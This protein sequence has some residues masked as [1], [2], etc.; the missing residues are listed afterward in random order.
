MAY[1]LKEMQEEELQ[2]IQAI[3]M[4]DYVDHSQGN[5]PPEITLKL[6]PLQSIVRKDVHAKLDLRV[7]YTSSYPNNPPVLKLENSKGISNEQLSKLKTDLDKMAIDLCGEVMILQL[8]Q[9]IQSFLHQHN[10]PNLS[11]FEQMLANQQKQE[12]LMFQEKQI[13][14]KA[15]V[16]KDREREQDVK[17]QVKEELQ[18]RDEVLKQEKKKRQVSLS[19]SPGN[20]GSNYFEVVD[21]PQRRGSFTCLLAKEHKISV[22]IFRNSQDERKVFCSSCIG[23][24]FDGACT[25]T[26]IDESTGKLM[27][28]S[29]WKVKFPTEQK[30]VYFSNEETSDAIAKQINS[31]EQEFYFLK[32]K[33]SCRGALLYH[34]LHIERNGKNVSAKL[35]M[36]AITG[37]PL[38]SFL[39]DGGLSISLLQSFCAQLVEILSFFHSKSIV[40]RDL[41]LCN[42]FVNNNNE[43]VICGYAV[44]RRLSDFCKTHNAQGS[45][46]QVLENSFG[47]YRKLVKTGKKGDVFNLGLLLV[48]LY[49]GHTNLVYPVEVPEDAPETFKSFLNS[50]FTVNE[51]LRP[52]MQHL[53]NHSFLCEKIILQYDAKN[54]EK[55]NQNTE[56][57]FQKLEKDEVPFLFLP[58]PVVLGK[59]RLMNEFEIM[60]SLGKGGFGSVIKVR[61]KLDGNL[62]A[63]KRIP[64]NP[65]CPHLNK[66]ITREVKLLSRL[67]HENVVRYFNSWI[68]AEDIKLLETSSTDTEL[69][70]TST[71]QQQNKK[72]GITKVQTARKKRDLEESLMEV[73][74]IEE[75]AVPEFTSDNNVSWCEISST[76]KKSSSSSSDDDSYSPK[77]KINI[78]SSSLSNR[79]RSNRGESSEGII[80][81]MDDS[82]VQFGDMLDSEESEDEIRV[83]G[84]LNTATTT[85]TTTSTTT[86]EESV[87]LQYLYIQM[88]YCERSTLRNVIDEDLYKKP[89]LVGRYFREIIEGL[90]HVHSQGIIHRDLKPFNIFIDSCDR[91]KIGDFGLATS[92]GNAKLDTSVFLKENEPVQSTDDRMTGKVGTA[93]YVA[94]ELCQA[95][96]KIKFSQK[97]DMYSLGVILFEMCY[98]PLNTGMERVKL[99]GSVRSESVVFPEDFN[100]KKYKREHYVISWLL[101]HN[102]DERP[103]ATELLESGY[104]PPKIED[105]QLDELLRHTLNQTNSTRYQRLMSTLFL[106]PVTPVLDQIYDSDC[107]GKNEDVIIEA[108][109]ILQHV[110]NV[111]INIFLKHEGVFV[112]TP[113]LTPKTKIFDNMNTASFIDQNGLQLCLPCDSRVSFA[114][115]ISRNNI[116]S[117]KR[118]FFGKLF[119]NPGIISAHPLALWEC[120]FDI[121]TN[122]FSSMLPESELIFIVF[123][124]IKEFPTLYNRNFYIRLNHMSIIKAVFV[125]NNFSEETQNTIL[126]ILANTRN[127]KILEERLQTCFMELRLTEHVIN[128]LMSFLTY[129]GSL[130]KAKETL[131]LLRKSRTPVSNL[132]KEAFSELERVVKYITNF[133]IEIPVSICTSFIG[134][135]NYY[136][137][138]VFQFVAENNRKRKH[139]G[140][141]ILAVGGCYNK[142]VESMS[143]YAESS[144]LP[145]SV[146]VSIAVEKLIMSVVE[147]KRNYGCYQGS[148]SNS[149]IVCC[150]T[151]TPN[152][153]SLVPVLQDLWSANIHASLFS[154]ESQQDYTI[155]EVQE[156]CIDNGIN[157]IV[158]LKES[159]VEHVRVKSRDKE[160]FSET[161]VQRNELCDYLNHKL[162]VKLENTKEMEQSLTK[163][164]PLY[165][166]NEIS[167][168]F[169]FVSVDKVDANSKKKFTKIFDSKFHH[170]LQKCFGSNNDLQVV[171]AKLDRSVL[172]IVAAYLE[173]NGSYEDF[174][175]SVRDI[176]EMYKEQ[177]S[178]MKRL[179]HTLYKVYSESHSVVILYSYVEEVY[180]VFT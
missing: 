10:V 160:K 170:E 168:L 72:K 60:Q 131:Q 55:Q 141:D 145:S 36:D 173:L 45:T 154:Y 35:L 143:R 67:N 169:T 138:I 102:P 54:G 134:N 149:V 83:T 59:S 153:D 71:N 7:K 32:S 20:S 94:P 3:Y 5:F 161:R 78:R 144:D 21:M 98:R 117:F 133:S 62:Y 86:S 135:V 150:V 8:A 159:D 91:I 30:K 56:N 108:G 76:E 127:K 73:N 12:E 151:N 46:G 140:V 23:H 178:F 2:A 120:S 34:S 26:A 155:E 33:L 43:I 48:C 53:S 111:V 132:T 74:G 124:I 85:T 79:T 39:Q 174:E 109:K 24:F 14:E 70:F 177:G 97:V 9:F 115:Y 84:A 87:S 101:N 52:T 65:K 38:S 122:G 51:D 139:G 171:A 41:N 104:V 4:D 95:K 158:V 146:G 6:T 147:E 63:I 129:D 96:S 114:R 50:C 57:S 107:H 82:M 80:F 92:H 166:S 148:A 66:R 118:F 47:D 13:K 137:G 172:K 58:N 19:Q 42:T 22:V 106:Q 11:F 31:I 125:Q 156:Y 180:K 17:R 162:S 130:S 1:A 105:S 142:L 64:L 152:L 121:V 176:M 167:F 77:S 89:D 75:F 113:L 16:A 18:K 116:N 110:K 61:N 90:A 69:D 157:H 163:T 29:E 164:V 44:M 99:L 136:S 88:E 49:Q 68:E 165:Q 27:S 126:E 28:I 175:S 100:K 25:M 179:C 93:L 37:P 103:S 15:K 40:H 123:E 81:Q 128:K 112:E 119:R